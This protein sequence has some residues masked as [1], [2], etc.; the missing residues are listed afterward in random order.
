MPRKTVEGVWANPDAA[1]PARRLTTS[2][3]KAI[4]I[5]GELGLSQTAVANALGVSRQTVNRVLANASESDF[6]EA[7]EATAQMFANLVEQGYN[8]HGAH[9]LADVLLYGLLASLQKDQR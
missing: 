4:A 3:V 8:R 1:P 5:A 6:H 2:A 9:A 7:N